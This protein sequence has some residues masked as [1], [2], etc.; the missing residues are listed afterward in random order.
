[1]VN[2]QERRE[3][4]E[5]RRVEHEPPAA[6]VPARRFVRV[7][8]EMAGWKKALLAAVA[9]V[10]PVVVFVGMSEWK[11]RG[12]R[13]EGMGAS[14]GGA[15]TATS[16]TAVPAV[17]S[18]TATPA[19]VDA[20][21]TGSGATAPSSASSMTA[22]PTASGTAPSGAPTAPSGKPARTTN[23]DPYGDAGLSPKPVV[24]VEPSAGPTASSAP[25]VAPV[26]PSTKPSAV[27]SDLVVR[28]KGTDT[29]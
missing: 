11:E 23:V 12:R 3:S 28:K 15:A 7:V 19:N 2:A 16:A 4:P 14:A 17:A 18:A 9:V 22:A 27:D 6:T 20:S 25:S 10:L 24:T 13:L 29:P 1:V 21:A 5:V 8:V 26:T